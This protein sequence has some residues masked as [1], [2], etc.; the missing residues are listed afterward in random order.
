MPLE[1]SP[2]RKLCSGKAENIAVIKLQSIIYGFLIDRIGI[3]Y[4]ATF[5]VFRSFADLFAIRVIFHRRRICSVIEQNFSGRIHESNPYI[6]FA[7]LRDIAQITFLPAFDACGDINRFVFQFV[8]IFIFKIGIKNPYDDSDTRQHDQQGD[9]ENGTENFSGHLILPP[10]LYPIPRTVSISV[11]H[12]P[13][14]WR[15]VLI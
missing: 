8:Q 11:L 2:D 14:F 4:A 12:F 13:S 1:K 6:I 5:A 7:L 9:S 10:I 15:S 3:P